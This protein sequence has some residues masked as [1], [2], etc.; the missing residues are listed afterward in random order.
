[1]KT[2][3]E[4]CVRDAANDVI[5]NILEIY[6]KTLIPKNHPKYLTLQKLS[7]IK[8]ELFREQILYKVCFFSCGCPLPFFGREFE[9]FFFCESVFV[10]LFVWKE[11]FII[12]YANY[13]SIYLRNFIKIMAK[14][15]SF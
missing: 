11:N 2:C 12:K 3:E 13:V 9:G 10:I 7:E 4:K 6:E 1:M 8:P 5:S 15:V 14:W